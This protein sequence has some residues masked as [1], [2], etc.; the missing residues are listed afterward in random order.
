MLYNR[1]RYAISHPETLSHWSVWMKPS[2]KTKQN[3]IELFCQTDQTSDPV[4]PDL[5]T[6]RRVE[7]EK[8]LANLLLNAAVDNAKVAGGVHDDA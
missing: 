4:L 3:Q 1:L 8:T 6:E 7:L 2:R 5:P